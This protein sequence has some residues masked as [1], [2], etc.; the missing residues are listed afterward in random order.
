ML[1]NGTETAVLPTDILLGDKLT[2]LTECVWVEG[3][4]EERT[5]QAIQSPPAPDVPPSPSGSIQM[6]FSDP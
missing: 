1:L 6:F 5:W 3:V 4:T 2:A